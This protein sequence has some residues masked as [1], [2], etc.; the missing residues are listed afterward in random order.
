[1]PPRRMPGT[2]VRRCLQARARWPVS[3]AH[4]PAFRCVALLL[5][6]RVCGRRASW[7]APPRPTPPNT[8]NPGPLRCDQPLDESGRRGARREQ[9]GRPLA[10]HD[11][12]LA[13]SAVR[14][15]LRRHRAMRALRAVV[16]AVICW[17]AAACSFA[18]SLVRRPCFPSFSL[19]RSLVCC[20]H[21]HQPPPCAPSI[22][23]HSKPPSHVRGKRAEQTRACVQRL[24]A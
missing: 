7:M 4:L 3:P 24:E 19:G 13:R 22:A 12:P 14:R 9:R 17:C 18:R 20:S 11:V 15:C 21:S 16:R 2:G 6:L 8:C 10:W 23:E 1:M 5:L